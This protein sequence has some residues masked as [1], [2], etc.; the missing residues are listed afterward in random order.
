MQSQPRGPYDVT[1]HY[2][3]NLDQAADTFDQ[4]GD[5]DD[6]LGNMGKDR[7]LD[8]DDSDEKND[9]ENLMSTA[10]GTSELIELGGGQP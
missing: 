3:S 5:S 8:Y 9:D 7:D 1:A 10:P 2:S 4:E 6:E